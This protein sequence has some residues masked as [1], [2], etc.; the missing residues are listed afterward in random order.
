MATTSNNGWTIPSDT[1]LVRDGALAIRTLGNGIDTSF[2][3]WL[4]TWTPTISGTGWAIGN[5]TITG[6][7]HKIG[8]TVH[9]YIRFEIGSTTTKGTGGLVFSLPFTVSGTIDQWGSGAFYDL[10]A[11]NYYRV[12]AKATSASVVPYHGSSQLSSFTSTTYPIAY[13]TGDYIELTG[14]FRAT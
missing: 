9:Y 2:G 11:T 12:S 4:T 14:T 1:D 6:R 7:Y 3:K 13:G 5:G 8:D 10:S